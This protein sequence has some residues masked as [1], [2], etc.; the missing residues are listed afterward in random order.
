MTERR[1]GRPRAGEERASADSL[2]VAAEDLLRADGPSVSLERIARAA[3][4]T[5]PILYHHVGNKDA[6]TVRL[7]ERL[8]DRVD[9]AVD[10]AVAEAVSLRDG[11][12]RFLRAYLDV[13]QRDRH[14]FV[15][16][17][18]G[19]ADGATDSLR[20]ADRAAEPLEQRYAELRVS[21]GADEKVAATWAYATIGMLHFVTLDWIRDP[22][23]SVDELADQ[24]GELLWS[25]LRT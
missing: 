16:V 7:A 20:L 3:G 4:G 21:Q 23:L 15:Y 18:G 2:L 9:V 14:I 24:L 22:R 11:I 25:G 6:L 13:V 1:S 19:G 10:A 12:D 5:K 17:S 8:N